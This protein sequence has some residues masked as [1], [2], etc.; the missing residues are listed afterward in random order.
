MWDSKARHV[1]RRSRA[2]QILDLERPMERCP[3]IKIPLIHVGRNE[4]QLSPQ[5]PRV[6]GR[7][8]PENPGALHAPR[9]PSD[10]RTGDSLSS[11]PRAS[12]QGARGRDVPPSMASRPAVRDG[13]GGQGDLC[14]S[15]TSLS[16]IPLS[17]QPPKR[18]RFFEKND[19]WE[20]MGHQFP[21]C[22]CNLKSPLEFIPKKKEYTDTLLGVPGHKRNLP[23]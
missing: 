5:W 8:P 1:P 15:A 12:R 23:Q 16:G 18:I 9:T 17:R 20:R 6:L 11:A 10:F 13:A 3:L 4:M 14:S 2:D 21:I 22:G 19:V 7:C